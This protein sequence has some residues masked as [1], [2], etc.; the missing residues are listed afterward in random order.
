LALFDL[1]R[2][3]RWS[4]LRVGAVVS[5]ALLILF[6]TV[7]FSGVIQQAFAR[8][9]SLHVRLPDVRGLRR[10]APVWLLGVGV[11][12]VREVRLEPRAATLTLEL[13]PGALRFLHRDARASVIASGLLGDRV[14]Q[15]E[16]GTA[17]APAL[18]PGDTIAGE[19]APGLQDLLAT[20]RSTLAHAARFTDRLDA[21]ART[22]ETGQGTA[23]KL[24]HDPG[25]Y[26]SATRALD[27]ATIALEQLRSPQ[28]TLR[29]LAESPALYQRLLAAAGALE[30]AGKSLGDRRGSLGLALH[31]PRLYRDLSKTAAGLALAVKRLDSLDSVAGALLHDRRLASELRGAVGELQALLRDIRSNPKRYFSVKVF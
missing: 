12:T 8:A 18:R 7:F 20:S 2:E 19:A 11:G 10:G 26:Q 23:G 9:A 31:D 5:L 22:I 29:Q 6:F 3:L 14:V 30:A 13:D 28:G 15:L 25:L 1:K 4:K 16:P 21:L 27:A 17:L 24:M